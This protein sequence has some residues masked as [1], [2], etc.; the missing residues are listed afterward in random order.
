M[1]SNHNHTISLMKPNN[2]TH[3]LTNGIELTILY[4]SLNLLSSFHRIACVALMSCTSYKIKHS[5]TQRETRLKPTYYSQGTIMGP[6]S[7]RNHFSHKSTKIR[8]HN[9]YIY[10]IPKFITSNLVRVGHPQTQTK[11][12]T[13]KYQ[14]IVEIK[15]T[16]H[17]YKC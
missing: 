6:S 7:D 10:N 3:H 13:Y 8:Q 1:K 16:R 2:K 9:E 15:I 11:A 17:K 5:C 14:Y 12:R 4:S